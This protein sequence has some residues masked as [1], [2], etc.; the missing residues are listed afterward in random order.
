MLVRPIHFDFEDKT[1]SNI[2]YRKLHLLKKKKK[3]D[4]GK[5]DL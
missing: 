4:H 2:K 3:K 1:F 5:I